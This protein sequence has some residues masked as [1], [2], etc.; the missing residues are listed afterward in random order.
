[1]RVTQSGQKAFTL[2][3]LMIIVVIMGVLMAI[4]IPSYRQ[5][6]VKSN[7]AEAQSFLMELA[8][9]QQEYLLQSR[10]YAAD[11]DSL[12]ATTP[13]NLARNYTIA[14]NAAGGP[15]PTFTITATPVVGSVQDGDGN[16]SLDQAGTK[17]WAGN[18]W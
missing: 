10:A 4:A 7:R 6:Q 15:P 8:Q 16:L 14:I 2:I 17:L 5:Y 1:M 9:R 18:P 11:V 12:N 13:D 3:E